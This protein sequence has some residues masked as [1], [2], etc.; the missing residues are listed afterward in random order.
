MAPQR[1]ALEARRLSDENLLRDHSR[2]DEFPLVHEELVLTAGVTGLESRRRCKI[3]VMS[4]GV[5]TGDGW[6]EGVN[7]MSRWCP[8]SSDGSWN[9]LLKRARTDNPCSGDLIV[10]WNTPIKF[11]SASIR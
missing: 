11:V 10:G 9:S 2:N 6:S 5:Y 1:A 7:T 3:V 8:S 4:P